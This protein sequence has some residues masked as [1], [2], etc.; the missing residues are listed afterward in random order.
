MGRPAFRRRTDYSLWIR[1]L[2]RLGCPNNGALSPD[3][4]LKPVRCSC[5]GICRRPRQPNAVTCRKA[6]RDQAGANHD[7]WH[8]LRRRRGTG[9]WARTIPRIAPLQITRTIFRTL[10]QPLGRPSHLAPLLR[11][12]AVAC[13]SPNRSAIAIAIVLRET[14][15]KLFQT[16]LQ[17]FPSST[18]AISIGVVLKG[19]NRARGNIGGR[20][21]EDGD[22]LRAARRMIGLY[23]LDAELVALGQAQFYQGLGNVSAVQDWGRVAAAVRQRRDEISENPSAPATASDL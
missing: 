18:C 6:G 1:D 2:P 9:A 4:S 8:H 23:G 13:E 5:T 10:D 7:Q 21:M 15:I 14:Q 16:M 20:F 22:V 19:Q 3:C 12:S 17:T 11:E